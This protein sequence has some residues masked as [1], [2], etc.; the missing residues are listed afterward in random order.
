M[1][2]EINSIEPIEL[3]NILVQINKKEYDYEALR[4][5]LNEYYSNGHCMDLAI[6]LHRRFG[7]EIQ[8]SI[9]IEPSGEEWIG[10]AWVKLPDGNLLDI[11]G[12]YTDSVELESFGDKLVTGL[13]EKGLRKYINNDINLAQDIKR[14]MVISTAYLQPQFGLSSFDNENLFTP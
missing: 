2:K 1:I 12:R 10:H 9:T 13:D 7:F 11:M 6:A 8:A 5:K 3:K 4:D 14:A